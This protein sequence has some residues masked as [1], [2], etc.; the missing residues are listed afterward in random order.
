MDA[1]SDEVDYK[2]LCN[3][4]T[5]ANENLEVEELTVIA[6][7]GYCTADEFVKCKEH[8]VK[9]IAPKPDHGGD[10]KGG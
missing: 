3:I 6:D 9:A 7:R 10:A 8:N 5:K 2:Q 1:V 4:A